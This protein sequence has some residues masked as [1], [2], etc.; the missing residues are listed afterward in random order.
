MAR[1]VSPI[2]LAVAPSSAPPGFLVGDKVG[3]DDR[4]AVTRAGSVKNSVNERNA[5]QRPQRR[6][7]GLGGMDEARQ[8]TIKSRLFGKYPAGDTGRCRLTH[9][10]ERIGVGECDRVGAQRGRQ[11]AGRQ[12]EHQPADDNAATGGVH[13][14]FTQIVLVD[15]VTIPAIEPAAGVASS[16][17]V[18][19]SGRHCAGAPI[20][21][22]GSKRAKLRYKYNCGS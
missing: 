21:W 11:N 17:D 3:R 12:R 10:G 13:K 15:V 19:T 4:L 20:K 1:T 2:I 22:T 5:H 18:L 8:R 6:T 16:A 9:T 7:V 14:H